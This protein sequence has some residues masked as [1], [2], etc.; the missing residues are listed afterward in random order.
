MSNPLRHHT[1]GGV[2][3]PP[4]LR[5]S[6]VLLAVPIILSLIPP[7]H[8]AAQVRDPRV[9]V[10]AS[11][12]AQPRGRGTFEG[13][14]VAW[15]GDTLVFQTQARDGI[16]G[17]TMR[18]AAASLEKLRVLE[19]PVLWRYTAPGDIGFYVSTARPSSTDSLRDVL[20]VGTAVELAG[21]DPVTGA[22]IWSRSDLAN[23]SPAAIDLVG[24][25]GYAVVTR[26][27]QLAVV[28]LGTGES[29]WS[30]DSLSLRSAYGWLPLYSTEPLMLVV[31][32]TNASP[33]TLM[34]VELG[35]GTVRWRQDSVFALPPKTFA[36]DGTTHLLGHQLPLEDTDTTFI[37]YISEEGP[38]RLDSRSGAVLWRA[39]GFR[40]AAVPT[41]DD[42]YARIR[43]R[44]GVLFVP[45]GKTLVGVNTSDGRSAWEA[46]R[47]FKSK[48]LRMDWSPHGVVAHG[49]DW[50][51]LVDPITGKSK[52]SAPMRLK[53]TTGIAVDGDVIYYAS[54]DRSM[55]GRA[56][57]LSDWDMALVAL[58][59]EDG[60]VR[61][62]ATVKFEENERAGGISRFDEGIVLNSWHNI[63]LVDREGS[64]RY[65]RTYQ[66]PKENVGEGLIGFRK[67]P[68][69]R[70]HGR[71]IYFFT[72]TPDEGG[73]EGFSVVKFDP[74]SGDETGRIWIDQRSP[75][76]HVDWESGS[77]YHR[78]DAREIVA[79]TFADRTA[80]AYAAENGHATTVSKLLAMGADPNTA[81]EDGWTSLHFAARAGHA[82][83]V[84]QLLGAGVEVDARTNDGWSAWM[85]AAR[86]GYSRADELL[87][88]AGAEWSDAAAAFFRGW[89]LAAQGQTGEAL[90]AYAEGE[91]LDSSWT[92]IPAALRALCWHGSV[93]GHAAEVLSACERAVAETP[94]SDRRYAS[95]RRARGIARALTGDLAGAAADLEASLDEES[96][97]EGGGRVAGWIAALHEGRSPFTPTVLESLR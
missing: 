12:K 29:R 17:D 46:P 35:T 50:I 87:R 54:A 72:S 14:V 38:I 11:V 96:R 84:Q 61:T 20:V 70:W 66:S 16:R 1:R 53:T 95:A 60:S 26:A 97:L 44:Q 89:H 33:V 49:K 31:G 64:V 6:P 32:R 68:T 28:D 43:S 36:T 2:A 42:G 83:V 10:G 62:I 21:I 67:R 7:A 74:A 24:P 63:A 81:D 91:A 22:T 25:T 3:R 79:L 69:T 80:L 8:A 93:W 76:Y 19:S 45:S 56:V 51:D 59:I 15:S 4:V 85:L 57:S 75:D 23:L 37:L 94:E 58:S 78:R 34:A 73:R 47:V 9:P 5:R 82:E 13:T 48:V 18:V 27:G 77:V 88:S 71:H 39:D 30:T 41:R 52:W 40:G 92:F 90:L 86:G 55:L 65:R